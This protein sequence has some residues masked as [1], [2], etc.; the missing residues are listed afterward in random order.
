MKQAVLQRPG[1]VE[2]RDVP[3]PREIKANEILLK[4]HR[5][6]VCG[7]DVHMYY[8]KHPFANTYPMVQ[9]HEYGGEVTAVGKDVTLLKPGMK[10]TARPHLV[11]GHC[12]ACLRGQYNVCQNLKVEGCAG[13]EGAAQEYFIIPEDRAVVI[14]DTLSYEQAAMIEPIAV[15][16]HATKRVGDLT[17]KNVVVTGAGTIGNLVAQFAVARG[18]KKVM[19]TDLVD[20]KLEIARE[21]GI[22][23]TANLKKEAFSDAVKRVFGDEGFQVAFEAVGVQSA[24]TELIGGV[25]NGGT[26]VIIGVYVQNPVV[27]MGFL[28]EHELNVLGSMMYRHEDYLEAVDW[29]SQ[30]KIKTSPLITHY[31]SLDEYHDAYKFIESNADQAVKV[32]IEVTE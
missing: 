19:I 26:V 4:I 25:E 14:P 20:H 1:L 15:G 10:A 21:C 18:A 5:V 17:G 13:P 2:I 27:N 6:G 11:C 32:M 12:P 22:S 3:L 16:A 24:L 8:G 28:G 7:S 30:G 31:F 23:A 29:V 9:G